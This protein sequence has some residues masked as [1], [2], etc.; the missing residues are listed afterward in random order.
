MALRREVHHHIVARNQLFDEVG[1][2]NV[3]LNECVI[4][5]RL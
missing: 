1:V 2:A 3:A 5:E 4:V